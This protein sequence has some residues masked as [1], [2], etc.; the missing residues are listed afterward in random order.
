MA[1]LPSV[2]GDENSWGSVLNEYL[3]VSHAADGALKSGSVNAS[4]LDV[5]SVASA[6]LL[7]GTLASRPAASVSSS[8]Y[9]FATD[10][11]SG[12]LFVSTGSSWTQVASATLHH[13]AH[14]AGAADALTGN[15]DANARV[16]ILANTI[17][18]GVRRK[19]N[20]VPGTNIAIQ[21]VDN[22]GTESVDVNLGIA[23]A[24]AV[25]NGGTGGTDAASA[26]SNLS[27][28]SAS[29]F[30]AMTVGTV[31]PSAPAVG[32]IWVDTN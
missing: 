18:I 26:R 27:V 11:N 29:G 16:G 23:G 19:L 24:V 6:L 22:A 25:A 20:L 17:A 2:G 21:A 28:A 15:L 12:T 3:L 32:D 1:R 10:L 30:A 14:Q 9:Y 13:S 5:S 31:A 7:R 8:V 4:Q